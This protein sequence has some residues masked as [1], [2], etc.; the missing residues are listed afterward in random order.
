VFSFA[1]TV[2][3]HMQKSFNT[4]SSSSVTA[5]VILPK[6]EFAQQKKS[7]ANSAALQ[8]LPGM[9]GLE[10]I[11]AQGSGGENECGIRINKYAS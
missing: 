8:C 6:V 5:L 9:N 11:R 10:I 2:F 7:M 3:M 4:S 1:A